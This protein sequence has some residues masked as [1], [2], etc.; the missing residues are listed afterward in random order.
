MTAGLAPEAWDRGVELEF[1]DGG[2]RGRVRLAECG[3]VRFEDAMRPPG[4][5]PGGDADA[6]PTTTASLCSDAPLTGE[7]RWGDRAMPTDHEWDYQG[8]ES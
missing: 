1:A 2:G 7:G 5:L 8:C 3:G 6:P 4:R